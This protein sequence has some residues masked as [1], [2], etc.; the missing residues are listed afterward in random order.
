MNLCSKT[1]HPLQRVD[2]DRAKDDPRNITLHAAVHL[3]PVMKAL[4]SAGERKVTM[5]VNTE[6]PHSLSMEH[7]IRHAIMSAYAGKD[8]LRPSSFQHS[9]SAS[10]G[11]RFSHFVTLPPPH[12]FPYS[13]LC[14]YRS[15]VIL[16]CYLVRNTKS[17]LGFSYGHERQIITVLQKYHF[18]REKR[19]E[20][21]VKVYLHQYCPYLPISRK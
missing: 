16:N 11:A 5:N 17:L 13:V 6:L 20:A 14:L 7:E 15:T 4:I 3:H 21:M 1:V 2:N 9:E 8:L 19:H 12:F 10:Q 18:I